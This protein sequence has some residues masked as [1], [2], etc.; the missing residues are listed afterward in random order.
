LGV[1]E[2]GQS[3]SL[4]D[5]YAIHRIDAAAILDAALGLIGR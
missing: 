4:P 1:T 5:A 2:F 3:S